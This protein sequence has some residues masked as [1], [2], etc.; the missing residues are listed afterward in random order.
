MPRVGQELLS[1]PQAG[2]QLDCALAALASAWIAGALRAMADL[3]L[4]HATVRTQFGRPI[5]GFQAIQQMLAILAEEVAAA[6]AA[7]RIAFAGQDFDWAAV[8]V[9]KV[10]T[11][12]AAAS[13][14]AVASQV[15]GALAL[16]D[17]YAV[18]ILARHLAEWREA[19]LGESHW[20]IRLGSLVKGRASS[21]LLDAVCALA[22][23]GH[24]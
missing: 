7:S 9:A 13:G 23:P 1:W 5:A 16:T 14:S 21:P 4:T 6:A 19:G 12:K 15:H 17:E 11:G 2:A 3:T 22:R 8:A 20:A 24:P 10:R 18:G